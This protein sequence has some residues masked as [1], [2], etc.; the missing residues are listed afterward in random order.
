M[1]GVHDVE[2][3]NFQFP[4]GMSNRSYYNDGTGVWEDLSGYFQFPVGMSNRS[5]KKF[6]KIQKIL[7]FSSFNSPWECRIGLTRKPECAVSH[8]PRLS[9]NSPW[10]CRIGLTMDTAFDKCANSALSIPRGNV[11]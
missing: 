9:F 1:I 10:E 5:Y 4:V 3:V 6:K 8:Q 2:I 7:I 11:E